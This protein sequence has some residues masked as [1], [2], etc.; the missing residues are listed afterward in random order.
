MTTKNSI[1]NGYAVEVTNEDLLDIEANS[2]NEEWCN[3]AVAT[4][5]LGGGSIA[6]DTTKGTPPNY[7]ERYTS[8][9]YVF[10]YCTAGK[11]VTA[12]EA[13]KMNEKAYGARYDELRI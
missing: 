5:R 8:E 13:E 7:A 11:C 3:I 10:R 12:E 2:T 9:G 6:W 1:T 4:D